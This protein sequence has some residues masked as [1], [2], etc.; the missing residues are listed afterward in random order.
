MAPKR[1]VNVRG[2]PHSLAYINKDEARMLRRMGG[3]GKP[4]P[5]G[6]PTFIPDDGNRGGHSDFGGPDGA[7]S[8]PSMGEYGGGPSTDPGN[9]SLDNYNYDAPSR[10]MG[11]SQASLDAQS[12]AAAAQAANTAKA[13]AK[14]Q[15]AQRNKLAAKKSITDL[16]P[17]VTFSKFVGAKM[18]DIM[19]KQLDAPNFVSAI[20][21]KK[22]R[23]VGNVTKNFLG[24]DVYTGMQVENY[25][26]QHAD[27]V[28]QDTRG[29]DDGDAVETKVVRDYDGGKLSEDKTDGVNLKVPDAPVGDG[30][31]DGDASEDAKKRSKMGKESTIS[32]TSQGL[33]S[34][35]RTRDR[36]LMSGL[37]S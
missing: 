18:R 5:S 14:E 37:I 7:P 28:A 15:L 20:F 22:G 33:L 36:S 2:Q 8:G 23:Y 16:L 9:Y 13:R 34:T 11:Q 35:A 1:K 31:G 3:S 12:R 19:G 6:I 17:G 25:T 26:G 10:G 27:L 29:G 32:T 21:D 24:L 4:G 30:I